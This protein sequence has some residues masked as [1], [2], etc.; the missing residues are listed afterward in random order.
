[1]YE[2]AD[3]A[4][5]AAYLVDGRE[6]LASR[7][8]ALWTVAGLDGATGFTQSDG[9][10]TAHGVAFSRGR[11]FF[12][13]VAS[14]SGVDPGVVGGLAIAQATRAADLGA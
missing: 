10:F 8:A 7:N 4:G 12:L 5:A 14:G 13:V 9:G 6:H 3:T 1:M 11:R 2:F